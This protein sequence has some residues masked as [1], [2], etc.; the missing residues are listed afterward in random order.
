M[1]TPLERI[2]DAFDFYAEL[3]KLIDKYLSEYDKSLR[4]ALLRICNTFIYEL[5]MKPNPHYQSYHQQHKE[6]LAK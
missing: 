3:E 5:N 1:R 6:M 4:K 2:R